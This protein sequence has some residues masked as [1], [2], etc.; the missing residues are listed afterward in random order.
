LSDPEVTSRSAKGAVFGVPCSAMATA[1]RNCCSFN[2]NSA[3]ANCEDC[4]RT[5]IAIRY[6]RRR[7]P[8]NATANYR[9]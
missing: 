3:P 4:L 5:V 6:R 8:A 9:D 1:S 7:E 2:E